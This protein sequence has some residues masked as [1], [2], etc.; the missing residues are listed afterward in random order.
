M[1]QT[2]NSSALKIAMAMNPDAK[3]RGREIV[4]LTRYNFCPDLNCLA[5]AP[6]GRLLVLDF[7]LH[8]ARTQNLIEGC[9]GTTNCGG[10]IQ[11]ILQEVVRER[12]AELPDDL[13][14]AVRWVK[15]S[16][17]C[18]L[19]KELFIKVEPVVDIMLTLHTDDL[20]KDTLFPSD[21]PE[22][23]ELNST[24]QDWWIEQQM[25]N[26]TSANFAEKILKPLYERGLCGAVNTLFLVLHD[27]GEG[28][29]GERYY[30]SH[31]KLAK[32]FP[33]LPTDVAGFD[34]VVSARE[35]YAGTPYEIRKVQL[36]LTEMI[37]IFAG[38]RAPRTYIEAMKEKAF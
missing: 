31:H 21:V 34:L 27:P 36:S 37:T 30:M 6:D 7:S 33:E 12:V 25:R 3:V 29:K 5:E 22:L 4:G 28:W 13:I 17:R 2:V 15:G 23:L 35:K 8:D 18:T 26:C 9:E 32:W 38:Q 14:L 19:V 1:P 20:G 16:M 11:E 24:N 10:R